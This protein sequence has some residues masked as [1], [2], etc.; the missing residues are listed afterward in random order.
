MG[1]ATSGARGSQGSWAVPPSG[2]V[3]QLPRL[4]TP[5]TIPCCYYFILIFFTKKTPFWSALQNR[6]T[7]T[8]TRKKK[9]EFSQK[10]WE[11]T[12]YKYS[13]RVLKASIPGSPA[14][15]FLWRA[16]RGSRGS[17]HLGRAAPLTSA[18]RELRATG[19]APLKGP[20]CQHVDAP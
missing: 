5:R 11:I 2:G 10:K 18:S 7:Q 19:R 15:R 17:Q 20:C 1:T 3:P 14:R 12:A 8:C 16:A 4:Q 13:L 9:K 6:C